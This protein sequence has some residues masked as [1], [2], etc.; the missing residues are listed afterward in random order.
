MTLESHPTRLAI[1][2]DRLGLLRALSRHIQPGMVTFEAPEYRGP[3]EELE[4]WARAPLQTLSLS[5]EVSGRCLLFTYETLHASRRH[6]REVWQDPFYEAVTSHPNRT[7]GGVVNRYLAMYFAV[8]SLNTVVVNDGNPPFYSDPMLDIA[9]H[10]LFC[11]TEV[12]S[13]AISFLAWTSPLSE[14]G[15][16]ELQMLLQTVLCIRMCSLALAP[17]NGPSSLAEGDLR[18]SAEAVGEMT[19]ESALRRFGVL[20]PSRP[21]LQAILARSA[22]E[23][24]RVLRGADAGG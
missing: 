2:P 1:L 4:Q 11:E 18:W 17:D 24:R 6:T 7:D 23:S 5:D 16:G 3:V 13:S 15:V 22:V 20:S 8:L 10:S 19:D 12:V 21:L 9:F 14:F